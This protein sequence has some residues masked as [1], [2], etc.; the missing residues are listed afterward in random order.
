MTA[1][2]ADPMRRAWRNVVVLLL[3]QAL[4]GCADVDDLHRRRA[5]RPDAEPEPLHRHA[6]AVDDHS[7]LGGFGPSAW[8]GSCAAT[9]AGPAFCWPASRAG[10]A[11]RWPPMR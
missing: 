8:R 6:A 11:R 4:L 7:W 2:P 5:G 10:L 3:A 9:A 1:A